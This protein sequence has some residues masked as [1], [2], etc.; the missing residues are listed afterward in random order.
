MASRGRVRETALRGDQTCVYFVVNDHLTRVKI[1]V[2]VNPD[3]RLAQLQT[4][5]AELLRLY[6]V[7]PGDYSVE[8][9]LHRQFAEHRLTGEWFCLPPCKPAIDRLL[10]RSGEIEAH[11]TY[12]EWEFR[13]VTGLSVRQVREAERMA[14]ELGVIQ[15]YGCTGFRGALR[16]A[17][18]NIRGDVWRRIQTGCPELRSL[19][20][21]DRASPVN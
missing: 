16:D 3:S 15:Y 5:N 18:G 12:D 6:G 10:G 13:S 1:G 7:V 21:I 2:S 20:D 14:Y 9:W 8:G 4:G 11:R 17:S 19:L